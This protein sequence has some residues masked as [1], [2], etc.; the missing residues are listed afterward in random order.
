MTKRL[1]LAAGLAFL[2]AGCGIHLGDDY[3]RRTR[4]ALDA[5]VA[6]RGGSGAIV[7]GDDAKAILMRHRGLVQVNT[8]YSSS[9]LGGSGASSSGSGPGAASAPINMPSP[10][11]SPGRLDA[12]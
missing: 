12:R 10:M 9:G 1:V 2:A 7:V 6:Q 8:Q 5:Q 4:S 3:G 11:G